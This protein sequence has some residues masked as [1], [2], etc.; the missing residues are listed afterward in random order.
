MVERSE[1]HTRVVVVVGKTRCRVSG[2][3]GWCMAV[4][5]AKK[6]LEGRRGEGGGGG[7]VGG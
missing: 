1:G 2:G 3:N 4:K 7:R 5:E 6:D